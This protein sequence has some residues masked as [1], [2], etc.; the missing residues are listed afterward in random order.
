MRYSFPKAHENQIKYALLAQPCYCRNRKA[1]QLR[2][3]ADIAMG[4]STLLDPETLQEKF[5]PL[6]KKMIHFEL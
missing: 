2:R 1:P 6:M 4:E 5:C 3:R